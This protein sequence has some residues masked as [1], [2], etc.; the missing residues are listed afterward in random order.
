MRTLTQPLKESAEYGR[1]SAGLEKEGAAFIADG[2]V[3]SQKLHLIYAITREIPLTAAGRLRLII[4]HNDKRARQIREEYRFYDRNTVVF[5]AKDLI[6]YQADLRG[7]EIETERLRCLRRL[8]EGRPT[9]VVTTFAALMTPQIPL[10]TLKESVLL[11]EKR[12]T[13]R[14]EELARRLIAMGYERTQQIE[15]PGQFAIR[16]DIVDI[17]DLTEETPCR[18]ELFGDEVDSIRSFDPESQRSTGQLESVRIYPASEMVLGRDRLEDGLFRMRGELKK[19][20]R[21][22]R[23]AHHMEAAHRLEEEIGAIL[24]EAE[25]WHDYSRL[26]SCIHYFYPATES[27]LGLFPKDGTLVFLDEPA[28][29]H[30]EAGAVETEFRESMISR[31]E[32]GYVLPGQMELLIPEEKISASL[33]GYRRLGLTAILAKSPLLENAEVVSI[34]ARSIAPYNKSFDA[35]E[36]DLKEYRKVKQKVVIISSSRTRARRLAQDLTERGLTAF[37]SENPDRILVPGEIMTYYGRIAHGF[38]YPK[39]K[40]SVISESDIF[41][42]EHVRRQKKKRFEGGDAIRSFSEL[43]PG[44]YVVHE[45]H[46]IGI[47]R[48]VEQIEV[49]GVYKD[50]VKIEYGGGGV[51]YVLP[52]ELN[53]LQKYSSAQ[54]AKPKLNRLGSQ[55][56]SGTKSKVRSAVEEIAQDLVELY[57][58][59]R[60]GAGH[61]FGRDTVWQKEFEEMF[62][63]E[64]TPDQIQAIEDTKKDMESSR[65]MDRLICGDVGYGKTEIAIRAAFKA[66][67]DGMQVAILVP[68]T[69]LAQQH[70]N[71]FTERMKEYPVNIDMLSRFRTSAE[72]KKTIEGLAAGRVDIV[73]GTHR[74]LS[75]DIRFKNL[76][77]LV[78]DEEQRFGVTHKEKIKKLRENVDV[79]TLTA[80]PIP[81]TLHMSLVGIRDMSV[82]EEAPQDRVPIQTYVMEY[83]E[84]LVREAILRELSR[85]GQVYYVYNMISDIAE[86]AARLQKQIPEARIAYAHGRMSEAELEKIMYDFIAGEVDVLV[87]TTIIETGLDISNVN[88]IIIHDSDRMGLSQLYQLR[89]R[90][91]RSDRTAYAFLMYRRDRL[92]K[93]EAE[94]RLSAI[95]EFTELG[96]GFR[97][98]MRDLEIRGAGNVLGK[99]QHGHMAAVGYDLYCKLLETAVRHV[100]GEETKEERNTSVNLGVMSFIPENY[101]PSET[102]KLEIY[103][104]IAAVTSLEECDDIRDELRDRYGDKIP[105]PAENL[106]RI[107]LIRSVAGRLGC[108]DITGRITGEDGYGRI[109]T[110]VD[111]KA[112]LH[113]EFIPDLVRIYKGDLTFS[114]QGAP[115]GDLKG[116]PYFELRFRLHGITVKDEELLLAKT[117]EFLIRMRKLLL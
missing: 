86:I 18:I 46:G 99:A 103:K 101:I 64:E 56:W 62:P 51:L 28:R 40:F 84:E 106:L 15:G 85:G 35:L 95:R 41:G 61:A 58:K 73:V 93:E 92:L 59:R 23:E 108:C 111:R 94:K 50:Y 83:N 37:Y 7:R 17:Y 66:V 109:R 115:R 77:L 114:P 81:R 65:I 82:L 13:I 104:K 116:M 4:T 68:T 33:S 87:S 53:V 5:P 96:S 57:A 47:Y 107:A 70:F 21:E 55:E 54:G 89:G 19:T 69:I 3:P 52:T 25:V 36:K 44:D 30:E 97:I 67:Q 16:G 79:L 113:G 12:G 24:E 78:V 39:L 20:A 9:T 2:C 72:Q 75:K 34:G 43:K 74:L 48:G 22:L 1:I 26:E 63:Y 76:G 10:K 112:A 8:M 98:A 6:F 100:K 49:E 38:E 80:T 31:A 42:A 91:G 90:V 105:A 71:T 45:D 32:K 88:T 117:E 60:E 14:E 110:T 27:F 11:I 29:I 102:Q